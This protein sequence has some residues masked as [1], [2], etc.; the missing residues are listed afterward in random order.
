MTGRALVGERRVWGRGDGQVGR[1]GVGGWRTRVGL[2]AGGGL[3][4]WHL[5]GWRLVGG[6]LVRGVRVSGWR[7]G[8]GLAGWGRMSG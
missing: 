1:G 2:L 5:A 6:R 8:G 3:V 4:R 7:V